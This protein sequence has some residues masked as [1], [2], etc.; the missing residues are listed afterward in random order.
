MAAIHSSNAVLTGKMDEIKMNLGLIRKDM[1][2]IRDRIAEVEN[3]ISL[4]EDT[5]THM[6]KRI[7]TAEN[8]QFRK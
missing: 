7:L 8:R 3:R 6:P 5:V 1:Q 2:S 4:L